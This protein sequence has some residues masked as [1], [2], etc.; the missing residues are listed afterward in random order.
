MSPRGQGPGL[1]FSSLY[2]P[3]LVVSLALQGCAIINILALN[4]LM[5]INPSPCQ[6]CV[7]GVN[8]V[9]LGDTVWVTALR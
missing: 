9:S 7:I 4:A 3:C 6:G 5:A 1:S 2:A 8:F